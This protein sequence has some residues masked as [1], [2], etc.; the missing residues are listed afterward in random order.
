MPG[1]CPI[2]RARDTSAAVPTPS[3]TRGAQREPRQGELNEMLKLAAPQSYEER[4]GQ[5]L[6]EHPSE[7]TSQILKMTK[8]VQK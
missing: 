2:G 7:D 5:G 1:P 6:E 8:L 4:K 3:P